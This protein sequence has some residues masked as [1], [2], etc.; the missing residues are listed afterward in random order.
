MLSGCDPGPS[1]ERL[2]V[3]RAG[4][5]IEVL[6]ALCEGEAI[7][8]ITA[9]QVGEGGEDEPIWRVGPEQPAAAAQPAVFELTLFETPAGY[10]DVLPFPEVPP[11]A[12]L[13]VGAAY[14]SRPTR[15]RLFAV[16]APRPHPS[17]SAVISG[18]G[19][20]RPPGPQ[21]RYVR[22][23]VVVIVPSG[24]TVPLSSTTRSIAG[25]SRWGPATWSG[26]SRRCR[27]RV[28]GRRRR[29]SAPRRARRR[30]RSSPPR[31]PASPR[32]RRSLGRPCRHWG[33]GSSR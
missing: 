25:A 14:P 8:G 11:P 24:D 19:Y 22:S 27:R 10:I 20:R 26:R 17:G 3:R 4:E 16:H 23:S 21:A 6:L 13:A 9:Y 7:T 28:G 12:A 33:S 1:Y 18:A 29:T 15:G 2:G 5:R 31:W 32:S 30:P